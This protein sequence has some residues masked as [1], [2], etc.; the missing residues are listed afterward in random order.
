VLTQRV[1]LWPLD[2]LCRAG[3][4]RLGFRPKLLRATVRFERSGALLAAAWA[5]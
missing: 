4:R 2:W 5:P 3:L 1:L